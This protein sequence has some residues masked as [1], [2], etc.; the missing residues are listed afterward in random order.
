MA[1]RQFTA[2]DSAAVYA[3][4][5]EPTALGL[6]VQDALGVIDKALDDYGSVPCACARAGL[7]C[8]V[9]DSG[10]LG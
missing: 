2:A 4:A 3:L 1:S 10:K 5:A 7:Q 9:A 6:K 8:R